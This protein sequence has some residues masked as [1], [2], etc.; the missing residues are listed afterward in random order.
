MEAYREETR[1]RAL[2][3][4]DDVVKELPAFMRRFA[5]EYL[6][7]KNK[8]PRTVL[9]YVTDI[10]IFL[11]FISDY[12][13][14]RI[15]DISYDILESITVDDMQDYFSYLLK[16]ETHDETT[17]KKAVFENDVAARARKLSSVRALYNYLIVHDHLSKNVA[18]LVSVPKPD[19][20]AVTYLENDEVRDVLHG[21][22]T[23]D[24]LTP[25]EYRISKNQKY[26]DIAIL[27]LLLNTGLRVSEMV[28]ID[29]SDIDWKMKKI[30]VYRKGAKE[31]FI[32]FN[33]AVYE[34]LRDYLEYERKADSADNDALFISRKNQR[35]TVRSVERIVKKYTRSVVPS[36][37]ITPHKLRSTFATALYGNEE[38]GVGGDIY[39]VADALGHSG[40]ETVKKYTNVSDERRKKAA[41]AIE[42]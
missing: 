27:T 40:L 5:N 3:K 6:V 36:K 28:G 13:D 19:D 20:R 11:R 21:A 23:G 8:S 41:S 15:K 29:L 42:Y 25:A 7:V 39:I 35:L 14:V 22:E 10:R 4:I 38:S 32:Y 1:S 17:G 33:D 18:A 30:G 34:A 24:S 16:Y 26:R 12:K 2:T 37:K 9:G 31:Q